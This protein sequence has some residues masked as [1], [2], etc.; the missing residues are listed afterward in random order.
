M[1][2]F[3]FSVLYYNMSALSLINQFPIRQ[4]T[5]PLGGAGDGVQD[6]LLS[7]IVPAGFFIGSVSLTLAGA[8]VTSGDFVVAY[9]AVSL[10]TTI[11]GAVGV[12]DVATGTF[13]F[14][15]NGVDALTIALVGSGGAWTSPA[16]VLFLRQI[17]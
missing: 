12:Q 10:S 16:S 13:F 9:D 1:G 15:S 2:R 3:Y 11:I 8:G 7:Q 17:A 6:V 14:E 5:V 4:Y